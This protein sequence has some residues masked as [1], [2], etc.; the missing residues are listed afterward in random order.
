MVK[1]HVLSVK[2]NNDEWSIRHCGYDESIATK[3]KRKLITDKVFAKNQVKLQHFKLIEPIYA[4]KVIYKLRKTAKGKYSIVRIT[5]APNLCKTLESSDNTDV[6][7]K[8]RYCRKDMTI[9]IYAY[10]TDEFKVLSITT[11]ILEEQLQI[12]MK[13]DTI[14]Y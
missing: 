7:S 6:S 1:L 12:L 8:I 5:I 10:S 14:K 13:H 9:T 4:F 11:P 2:E 3:L